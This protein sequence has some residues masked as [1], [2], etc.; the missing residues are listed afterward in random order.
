MGVVA[1]RSLVVWRVIGVMDLVIGAATALTGLYS[2]E[3]QMNRDHFIQA[4][5]SIVLGL[6]ISVLLF[7]EAIHST[8]LK[9]RA[10]PDDT[11]GATDVVLIARWHSIVSLAAIVLVCNTALFFSWL[12]ISHERHVTTKQG[13][14]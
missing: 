11:V 5:S 4:M 8:A 7:G 6:F 3:R 13:G 14:V 2:P 1:L 9:N 10:A 12:R